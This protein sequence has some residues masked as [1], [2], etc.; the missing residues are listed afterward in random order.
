MITVGPLFFCY[1][2]LLKVNSNFLFSPY[3]FKI[4]D[5]RF[6][7]FIRTK[8]WLSLRFSGAEESQHIYIHSAMYCHPRYV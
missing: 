4:Q 1:I 6:K 7:I 2:S 3:L 8:S 5:S